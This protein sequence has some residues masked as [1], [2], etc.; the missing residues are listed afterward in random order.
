MIFVDDKTRYTWVYFLKTK[1]HTVALQTFKDFKTLIEKQSGYQIKRFRCDNGKGE[2]D[3]QYFKNYL[4]EEGISYEP[5]AAYTQNQNGV[6]ERKICTIS[7]KTRSLLADAGLSEGF[8]E[9]LVRTAV[10]LSNRSPTRALPFGVTPYEARFG[11]K[12]SLRHLRR[13]GSEAIVQIHPDLHKRTQ[14]KLLYCT[15]LGYV[16]N[17]TKQYRVW[18]REGHRLLTVASQNV[19]IDEDSIGKG[20]PQP[21]TTLSLENTAERQSVLDYLQTL[22]NPGDKPE[23]LGEPTNPGDKLGNLGDKLGNQSLGDPSESP[24]SSS[25]DQQASTTVEPLSQVDT[26]S[27][28]QPES[29]PETHMPIR[30]SARTRVPSFKLRSALSARV[31]NSEEPA[32]YND[33]LKHQNAVQWQKAIKEE[34]HSLDL[35]KTWDLVDEDALL[36]SGKRAIGCKW[37]FKQKRNADGSKRFKARLVIKG[38]EQKHGIDYEETFAPVAKFVT[39]RLLFALAAQYNWEI[40]QMDVITAFLNPTLHEEV[41]MELPEGYQSTSTSASGG[42]QYCRLKKSLYGLKQAPRAWYEDI[43]AFLTGSLGLTRS[44]EDP[45]LYIS[46]EA[47]IILLLWV[48]D[49]LL[50]SPNKVA[51]QSLKTKLSAK[52]RMSDLGP[53]QQFLGIQIE[54]DRQKRTLRIHQKPYIEA[55]LKRFQMDNCNGVAT[56][57]ETNLQLDPATDDASPIERIDYQRA[58]GSIMYAMLGTRPD[59]AFA[60]SSLSQYCINPGPQH[61]QAVQR[62]LRYL[63]RTLDYGITYG[64]PQNPAIQ[65]VL[66]QEGLSKDLTGIT[67]FGFTDSDWAGDR[68]SR[69]STSGYLYNLYEGAISWKS[70]KQP[71]VATSSTEAEYIACTE[72]AKEGL[73]LRRI[74]AEI[75]GETATTTMHYTHESEL[76]DF[77]QVLDISGNS[78]NSADNYITYGPQIVFADNQGA[79]KLSK[80]PQHHNRTKHIDVKYHFIRESTQR[81]LIQLAYIPTGEMVADILTKSLPR[82]RHEKHM[83]SMGITGSVGDK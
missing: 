43:D 81:G 46:Q 4:T 16:E 21:Q 39:V 82:D 31:L 48:D 80:N 36:R 64:G 9:E 18:H 52:Y 32:S 57:M 59:L 74:M 20:I 38:Y 13:I 50:F 68:N 73:W 3:N 54:R 41:Y 5:S 37:V 42:K 76:H 7:N 10:Y 33:A 60:V 63:K 66:R 14:S 77:I 45:N 70:A 26:Q 69:K 29:P 28:L 56:P 17:T 79:I 12:P 47:N 55:I 51:I 35:N 62:V 72:A 58:I 67:A 27:Q 2:Y 61:A 19:D 6:S 15:F 71:I 53:V 8:W 1:D 65:D 34:I 24:K 25:K 11:S 44:K 23:N 49:I 83:R 75:R 22:P 30:R 78:S 40:D